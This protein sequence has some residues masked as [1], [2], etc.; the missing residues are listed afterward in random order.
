MAASTVNLGPI[1][2]ARRAER[3]A[4]A[5]R[6]N[7]HAVALYAGSETE[8][9]IVVVARQLILGRITLHD[10]K[11][12]VDLTPFGA[13]EGGVSRQHAV[14]NRV[15]GQLMVEDMG[16]SNGTRL[17]GELLQPYRPAQ[18]TSGARLRLGELDIEIYLPK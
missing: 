11:E 1:R 5:S 13:V 3:F 14:L 9:L 8:P 18:I 6:L 16:S 10:S 2:D 7:Q 12:R 4:H 15:H 17:N